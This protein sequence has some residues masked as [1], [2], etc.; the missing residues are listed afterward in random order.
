MQLRNPARTPQT[1]STFRTSISCGRDVALPSG[2]FR[3]LLA[4]FEV[5]V[6]PSRSLLNIPAKWLRCRPARTLRISK[7]RSP[8]VLNMPIL[9]RLPVAVRL[10]R[11]QHGKQKSQWQDTNSEAIPMGPL[12]WPDY[13]QLKRPFWGPVWSNPDYQQVEIAMQ[14]YH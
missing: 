3:C 2:W 13:D 8:F 10:V 14:A 12:L 6:G 4:V 7:S 1:G 5:L 9:L 11:K